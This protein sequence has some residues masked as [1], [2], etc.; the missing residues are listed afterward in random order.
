MRNPIAERISD[1]LK[2]FAPFSYL[3]YAELVSISDKIRVLNLDKGEVL[4]KV[5][6]TPS[7]YFY[8]V[9]SGTIGLTIISDAED[10]LIDKCTEGAIIGLRPIFAK[11]NY[12][13]TATAREDAIVYAISIA[14]FKDYIYNHEEV[15]NFFLESFSSNTRNPHD[16]EHRGKL[17]SQNIISNEQVTTDIQYFQPIKY[18]A[19]PIVA[20]P[21][22]IV[23]FI[24]QTMAR[25]KIGSVIIQ[26][27]NYPIGIVTDHD[28]RAKIA[29]GLFEVD[30]KTSDIMSSPVVTVTENISLAEAQMMML[31]HNVGYLCVTKDGTPN[32]HISGIISEHD[33][34]VAQANNPGVLLKR[35]KKANSATELKIIRE[36]LTNLI[37]NSVDKN[38]PMSHITNVASEIT[39]ALTYRI[40]E[41]G[42]EELGPTPST[43]AWFNLGSQGRSE[44]TL[45]TDVDNMIVFNDVSPEN[46]D[47]TQKYFLKL[48]EFVVDTFVKIGYKRCVNLNMATNPL[49]CKSLTDWMNQYSLWIS[50]PGKKGNTFNATFF[51]FDFIYGD[52]I[53]ERTLTEEVSTK[54]ADN[55]MFYAYLGTEVIKSPP[56]LSFFGNLNLETNPEGVEYFDL[57]NKVLTPLVNAARV[58]V[59]N[60][61]IIGLKNT[62]QRYKMLA[63]IDEKNEDLF[64]QCAEAYHDVLWLKTEYGLKDEVDGDILPIK[65]LTKLDITKLKSC[66]KVISQLQDLIKNRFQLTYFT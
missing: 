23:K 66:I 5:D 62:N 44:Q 45:L 58:L 9:S 39:K 33:V 38:I 61:N 22:D 65:E 14:D 13:M 52:H 37:Q 27:N 11:N 49:W 50:T 25:T 59:L 17:I 48:A 30:C 28:L 4:F 32:T 55:K 34:V 15:T 24:A 40:I 2:K 3:N 47:N 18:N 26:E 53:I 54:I 8:I 63:E 20:A 41:L 64:L 10:N 29:T 35:I 19:A 56:G 16:E 1:F 21:T 6:Q 42:I 43:F 57:K 46:Y 31:K 51:D 7:Q 36:K 60:K 12:L